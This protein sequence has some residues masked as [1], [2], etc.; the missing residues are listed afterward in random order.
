MQ[1]F[2]ACPPDCLDN[3][4]VWHQVPSSNFGAYLLPMLFSP[5][6]H[7]LHVSI[8]YL[9][10]LCVAHT[11]S[12]MLYPPAIGPDDLLAGPCPVP[13]LA[14]LPEAERIAAL[15]SA[16]IEGGAV[17]ADKAQTLMS[18]LPT[19]HALVSVGHSEEGEPE[20]LQQDVAKAKVCLGLPWCL[21]G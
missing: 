1:A 14:D 11:L 13:E 8:A 21:G 17:G 9:G 7:L 6:A 3:S 12:S 5:K 16:G 18:V 15:V 20:I 2:N 10:A 4:L 19:V